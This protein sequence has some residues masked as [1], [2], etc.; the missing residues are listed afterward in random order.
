MSGSCLISF[1]DQIRLL[2]MVIVIQFSSFGTVY[3]PLGR[4]DLLL[5]LINSLLSADPPLPFVFAT[6]TTYDLISQATRDKVAQSGLGL[7]SHFAPQQMVLQHPATGWFLVSCS[8]FEVVFP[9]LVCGEID[10]LINRR[11]LEL[12]GCT[13]RYSTRFR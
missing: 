11:T 9:F 13:K 6:V 7:I 5:T 4:P 3:S 8:V 10:S 12:A 2:S 1:N